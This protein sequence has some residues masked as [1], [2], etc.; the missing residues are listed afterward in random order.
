VGR[1]V[2]RWNA[3]F[4]P[5]GSRNHRCRLRICTQEIGI[6]ARPG[7]GSLGSIPGVGRGPRRHPELSWESLPGVPPARRISC[8]RL[9]QPGIAIIRQVQLRIRRGLRVRIFRL[10][11]GKAPDAPEKNCVHPVGGWARYNCGRRCFLEPGRRASGLKGNRRRSEAH[12]GYC[13]TPPGSPWPP[14]AHG[15]HDQIERH[16]GTVE[17]RYRE[18]DV[19]GSTSALSLAMDAPALARAARGGP[20]G[21][22]Q[23]YATL[24][25][26]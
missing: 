4:R 18:F 13:P 9:Q 10:V 3:L 7:P 24:R 17:A 14:R 15:R 26:D 23:G 21:F 20:R 6:W 11:M 19:C 16:A 8:R 2:A 12:L 22:N 1:A 25:A 5:G